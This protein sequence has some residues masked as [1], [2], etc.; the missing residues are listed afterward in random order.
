MTIDEKVASALEGAKVILHKRVIRT[1]GDGSI[2]LD[3]VVLWQRP[4][5]S[6]GT[7]AGVINRDGSVA[8]FWGHYEMN[9]EDAAKDYS[10]RCVRMVT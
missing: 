1:G 9:Y 2:L 5:E 3:F 8:L 7:H 6:Y 10:S 4:D